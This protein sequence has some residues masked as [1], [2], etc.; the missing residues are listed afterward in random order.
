MQRMH[1]VGGSPGAAA[2]GHSLVTWR[3]VHQGIQI[4]DERFRINVVGLNGPAF[5]RVRESPRPFPRVFQRALAEGA[6]EDGLLWPLCPDMAQAQFVGPAAIEGD[7]Y[8]RS[9][10]RLPLPVPCLSFVEPRSLCAFQ[11]KSDPEPGSSREP[12]PW[13]G[14][15]ACRP[16]SSP[17]AQ[18]ESAVAV[19]AIPGICPRLFTLPTVLSLGS[20]ARED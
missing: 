20:R 10:R 13:L 3:S 5:L 4:L 8:C 16:A 15:E 9:C 19:S 14:I 2:M 12:R 18:E 6:R 17:E 1:A 11:T 7:R